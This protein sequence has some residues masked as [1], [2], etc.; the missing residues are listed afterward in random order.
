MARAPRSSQPDGYFHV[1]TRGNRQAPVFVDGLDLLDFANRLTDVT[2]T[3]EWTLSGYCLMPNHVHLVVDAR[4]GELS[5]GMRLLNGWYAQRFNKRHALSGH[6]FQG[7]FHS[8][9]VMR[10]EHLLELVR[11]LALNPVRAGLCTRPREWKWGSYGALV[12]HRRA[13]SFFDAVAARKLFGTDSSV[14]IERIREFVEPGAVGAP[15]FA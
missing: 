8:E 3:V 12:G 14:A 13:P 15:A 5:R 10:D 4:V 6:T 11:Y 9:P 1:T 7:R 2:R